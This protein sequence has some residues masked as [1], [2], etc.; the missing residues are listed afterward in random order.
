[1]GNRLKQKPEGEEIVNAFYSQQDNEVTVVTGLLEEVI[2]LGFSRLFPPSIIYGSLVAS[3]LGHELTHGFNNDGK[4]F[5]GEGYTQDWWE[6]EDIAAF[7][8]STQCMVMT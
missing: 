1:M 4:K 7:N 6:P 8:Y 2:D 5:D 3:T